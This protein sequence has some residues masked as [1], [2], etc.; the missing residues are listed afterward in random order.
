MFAMLAQS[1]KREEEDQQRTAAASAKFALFQ[2]FRC[3]PKHLGKH[4]DSV[5]DRF[6]YLYVEIGIYLVFK[7]IKGVIL[8]LLAFFSCLVSHL[9]VACSVFSKI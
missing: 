3:V 8:I 5:T 4:N 1:L 9:Q 2:V 6:G 7:K